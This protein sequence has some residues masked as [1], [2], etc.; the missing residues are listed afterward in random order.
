MAHDAAA[1]Q[2]AGERPQRRQSLQKAEAGLDQAD[3]MRSSSGLEVPLPGYRGATTAT[4]WPKSRST[5]A[6]RATT[7]VTPLT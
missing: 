7:V 1:R 2:L 3:G 5:W 4:S 6:I